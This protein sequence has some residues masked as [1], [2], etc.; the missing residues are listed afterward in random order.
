MADLVKGGVLSMAVA[1]GALAACAPMYSSEPQQVYANNPGVTY[2]YSTDEQLLEAN[3]KAAAYCHQYQTTIPRAGG[4]T[5]NPDGTYS[6]SFECVP[7][8]APGATVAMAPPALPMTY[9]YR[10]TQELLQASQ[11]ADAMCMRYGK[12]SNATITSNIDGS[13]TATFTCVP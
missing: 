8:T 5:T 6:V 4:I 1:A 9:T 11:D 13:K 10:T 3:R 2:S 7:V 12:R